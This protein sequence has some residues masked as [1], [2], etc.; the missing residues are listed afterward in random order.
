MNTIS[1][2]RR[3][4]ARGAVLAAIGSVLAMQA[5]QTHAGTVKGRIADEAGNPFR[6]AHAMVFDLGSVAPTS[7]VQV[8]DDGQFSVR[9]ADGRP[10]VVKI[11][12][13]NA[14][15]AYLP[16]Q[17]SAGET[18]EVVARL[19][20]KVYYGD[21]HPVIIGLPSSK[22]AVEMMQQKDLS[23]EGKIEG[24]EAAKGFIFRSALQYLAYPQADSLELDKSFLKF[25][26]YISKLNKLPAQIKV[27][28]DS[29]RRRTKPMKVT[30]KED[31]SISAKLIAIAIE[32]QSYYQMTL[33]GSQSQSMAA[34]RLVERVRD[35][36][37]YLRPMPYVEAIEGQDTPFKEM[38]ETETQPLVREMAARTLINFSC[39]QAP[40]RAPSAQRSE[41]A[42]MEKWLKHIPFDSP[43]WAGFPSSSGAYQED[44]TLARILVRHYE[45]DVVREYAFRFLREAPV[46]DELRRYVAVTALRNLDGRDEDRFNEL[47]QRIQA[48]FSGQKVAQE[49]QE[50]FAPKF[51]RQ[52][53]QIGAPAPAFIAKDLRD[54]SKTITNASLAGKTYL[55]DFW[56]TTCSP[57][58]AQMPT[59]H[60]WY[61]RY[62][63]KGFEIVSFSPD[64]DEKTI[65]DFQKKKFSMP[66]AN[67]WIGPGSGQERLVTDFGVMGYPTYLLVDAKG[68]ITVF[69]G[70]IS[71]LRKKLQEIFGS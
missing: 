33:E 5:P 9:V 32:Y 24:E 40:Y 67:A 58:I 51:A 17:T 68:N 7:L 19:M 23:W 63:S 12:G 46:S 57:C 43:L 25:D 48:D 2:S 31:G 59:L 56:S 47:Y 53:L 13:V 30:V 20:P 14:V 8:D 39:L 26:G 52:Q 11:M 55:V 22:E 38:L 61:E 27:S 16:V 1:T 36:V 62:R 10:V 35:G 4:L 60:E 45:S 41:T 28:R 70:S 6:M 37:G 66:W 69:R 44:K 65:R 29:F 50:F 64:P 15:P 54:P 42:N 3:S 21:T 71:D 34:S 49:V 18:V